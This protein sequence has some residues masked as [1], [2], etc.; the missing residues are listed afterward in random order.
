MRSKKGRSGGGLRENTH[1]HKA[2]GGGM[3]ETG[4]GSLWSIVMTFSTAHPDRSWLKLLALENMPDIWYT[5]ETS[6]REMSWLKALAS[7]NI[8]FIPCTPLLFAPGDDVSQRE[9]SWLKYSATWNT[10]MK[11]VTLPTFQA[12]MS[13][14]ND[15][16]LSNIRVRRVALD[17][18]HR[19]MSALNM[20]AWTKSAIKSV[21]RETF[22]SAIGPF[23]NTGSHESP[24]AWAHRGSED[25]R[26]HATL[27]QKHC[28]TPDAITAVSAGSKAVAAR[29]TIATSESRREGRRGG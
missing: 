19:D 15:N 23:G 21:T 5:F 29:T 25:S 4:G 18:S 27:P 16:A 28:N 17:T 22:H 13:A 11:P 26:A 24:V 10:L 9:M 2:Q 6:H 12:E 1:T 3:I 7:L 8:E 20:E 14:L